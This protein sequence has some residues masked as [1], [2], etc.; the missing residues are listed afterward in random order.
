VTHA[1]EFQ[2]GSTEVKMNTA[3]YFLLVKKQRRGRGEIIRFPPAHQKKLQL[4]L[5]SLW[6][7]ALSL[8][9]MLRAET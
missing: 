4:Q 8:L 7:S 5:S 9:E 6:F 3:I 1:I 2:F